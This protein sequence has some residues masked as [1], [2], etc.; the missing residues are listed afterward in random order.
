MNEII[1]QLKNKSDIETGVHQLA[2]ALKGKSKLLPSS[3]SECIGLLMLKK[4]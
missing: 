3:K 2:D 1:E 4:G